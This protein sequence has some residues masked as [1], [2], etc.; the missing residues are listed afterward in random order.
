MLKLFEV[1]NFFSIRE[2]Q[3]LDL[4]ASDS[5]PEL[6]GRL[7]TPY[8]G[9]AERIT[10]L[11]SIFGPN[12][13]GK[14]NIL[15]A[16]SFLTQFGA[17]RAQL[18]EFFPFATVSSRSQ[19]TRFYAEFY[20]DL[21]TPGSPC[22][23]S[24]E[25]I[26]EHNPDPTVHGVVK[27]EGL[28]YFPKGR[29]KR[30]IERHYDKYNTSVEFDLKNDDPRL[31]FINQGKSFIPI[32]AQ[33]NHGIS[34]QLLNGLSR[35]QANFNASL[36]V[37]MQ[38]EAM[39]DYYVRNPQVLEQLCQRI[40]I[41]DLGIENVE[42]LGAGGQVAAASFTHSGLEMPIVLGYESEGTKSFYSLFPI[43]DYALTNGSLVI[44]D[45]LDRDIHP[46]LLPEIIGWFFNPEINKHHAQLL[47][48]CQNATL[49]ES[50]IKEEVFLTEKN[51]DGATKLIALQDIK[52]VR[53]GENL[54]AK[55]LA[56]VYGAVPVIG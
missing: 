50:L 27:Y 47:M 6:P 19:P 49:L 5:A 16:L 44:I 48:S 20:S 7:I 15:K 32:L 30:L 53:R 42:I 14:S 36:R 46:L 11:V 37:T 39:T 45:E 40:R 55:Y 28:K 43:L 56:G 1:E 26:I 8:P 38:P 3:I 52:G 31:T 41:M 22:C 34:A 18:H 35:I 54:Y 12:A 29:P 23:Y 24:Y 13:S 51:H 2:R 33:F 25:L 10:S 9:C 4:T 17:G 21:I